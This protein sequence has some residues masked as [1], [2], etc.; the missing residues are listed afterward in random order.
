MLPLQMQ[1]TPKWIIPDISLSIR[2]GDARKKALAMLENNMLLLPKKDN[3]LLAND[4][5]ICFT[6][7]CFYAAAATVCV[8]CVTHFFDAQAKNSAY[9]T[10]CLH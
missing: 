2:F 10:E 8:T 6:Q 4:C 7:C 9:Y 3:I 5:R 1:N